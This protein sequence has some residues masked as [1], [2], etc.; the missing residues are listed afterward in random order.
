[1][2]QE[3]VDH[4]QLFLLV[5]FRILA[6]LEVA[7]LF[8]SSSIPQT[9]KIGLSAFG[10]VAVFPMVLQKGY[11]IPASPVDYFLLVVGEVVI[12]LLIGLLLQLIF[13]AFQTAGQFFSL[14]LGFGASEVFDPLAQVELPLMGEFLNIVALLVFIVISGGAKFFL[15]GVE[16]S[17]EY[18]QAAD[19]VT[20]RDAVV[21]MLAQ[22]LGG[23]FKTALTI[24]FPI[25]GT[26]TLVSIVTGLLAKA[27][28]QLDILT[29]GF[30]LSIGVAFIILYAGMP[31]LLTAFQAIID[32]SF[33][34]V[35][36]LI[37]QLGVAK[38]E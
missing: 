28:P 37:M 13:A 2:I 3:L 20:H 4:L 21:S 1:M 10:A 9:A 17:F 8:S 26:L 14:Q 29:M 25:L 31:F 6:M 7:P 19:L 32:G 5:L 27:S 23:L 16:R 30:P 33:Q 12:G 38:N 15:I 34:L 24:S 18:L 36:T 22:G 35:G 11:P